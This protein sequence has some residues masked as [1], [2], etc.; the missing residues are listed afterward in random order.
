MLSGRCALAACKSRRAAVFSTARALDTVAWTRVSG[1]C[2]RAGISVRRALSG[3]ANDDLLSLPSGADHA[4]G[5]IAVDAVADSERAA[6]RG[7]EAATHAALINF[8]EFEPLDLLPSTGSITIHDLDTDGPHDPVVWHR[9]DEKKKFADSKLERFQAVR[10]L[11]S[12]LAPGRVVPE[13]H[14]HVNKAKMR[15]LTEVASR[16]PSGSLRPQKSPSK[17]TLRRIPS[18]ISTALLDVAWHRRPLPEWEG[19]RVSWSHFA[20][21]RIW[22][23]GDPCAVAEHVP[24]RFALKWFNS[25]YA[26]EVVAAFGKPAYLLDTLDLFSALWAQFDEAVDVFYPA[27]LDLHLGAEVPEFFL[28]NEWQQHNDQTRFRH[29]LEIVLAEW[30]RQFEAGVLAVHGSTTLLVH[31]VGLFTSAWQRQ[32]T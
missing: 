22:L 18:P 21:W 5:V 10:T 17:I 9:N 16:Q 3:A 14:V 13:W 11:Q 1:S 8:D 28:F 24:P 4:A 25:P 31:H 32:R 12:R 15:A 30:L 7:K 23:D 6:G 29:N 27:R 26:V 19:S 20:G 2:L